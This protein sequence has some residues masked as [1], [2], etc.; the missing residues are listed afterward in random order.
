MFL[1]IPLPFS[2][3][4]SF[5]LIFIGK[6]FIRTW[7]VTQ[8]K[9]VVGYPRTLLLRNKIVYRYFSVISFVVFYF[10]QVEVPPLY[11]L[12]DMQYALNDILP[13]S[14][15]KNFSFNQLKNLLLVL[16]LSP[17]QQLP[18]FFASSPVSSAQSAILRQIWTIF[19]V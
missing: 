19:P 2:S 10:K 7:P 8:S 1:S 12:Y 15:T 6:L 18:I 3:S 17:R 5:T 4:I 13:I 14:S 9:I 11:I 16:F